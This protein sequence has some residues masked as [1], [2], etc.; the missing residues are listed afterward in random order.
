MASKPLKRL[1][2][3]YSG[4]MHVS[5]AGV[6]WVVNVLLIPW[7]L[8]SVVAYAV[9]AC[10]VAQGVTCEE[11]HAM[12][13]AGTTITGVAALILAA[14]AN[15]SD[16]TWYANR[17]PFGVRQAAPLVFCSLGCNASLDRRHDRHLR[18][19][20]HV[21][22]RIRRDRAGRAAPDQVFCSVGSPVSSPISWC[23]ALAGGKGK[24]AG[25]DFR[26]R[27]L[28]SGKE[29]AKRLAQKHRRRL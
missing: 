16:W 27:R 6:L 5:F 2:R 26:G 12:A 4:L 23:T 1:R 8:M 21:R 22:E 10:L 17:K 19:Q 24:D 20:Q 13:T 9:F 7:A 28:L 29:H 3:H 18:V 11:T 14:M 25:K 15:H